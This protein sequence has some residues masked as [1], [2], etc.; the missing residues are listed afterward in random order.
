MLYGIIDIGSNTVRL[1]VYEITEGRLELLTKRKHAV[2]LAAHIKD[3]RMTQTGVDRTVEILREFRSFLRIMRIDRMVAFATA[4][5]RNVVNSREAVDEISARSG[6]S[7][8]L[9][10]GDEEATF[11]FVGLTHDLTDESGLVVDIG[12]ASTELI[13]FRC[14]KILSKTSLPVGSLNMRSIYVKDL[15][16]TAEECERISRAVRIELSKCEMPTEKAAKICGIGGTFKGATALYNAFFGLEEGNRLMDAAKLESLRQRFR[17]DGG[18]SQAEAVMML[19]HT[20]DRIQTLVPGLTVAGVIMERFAAAEVVY[21]DSG[22][23][24]GYI[25]DQ[26]LGT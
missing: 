12:G 3:G 2:G 22:V 23:R 13:F 5:L 21:S 16:P 24:E 10:S 4:A 1:A 26:I 17:L 14:R 11:A 7:V 15:L 20:P 19:K 8:R 18:Y 6:V 25:Y 9:I